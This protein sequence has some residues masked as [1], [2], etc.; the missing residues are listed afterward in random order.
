[1]VVPNNHGFLVKMII[2]GCLGVLPFKETPAYGKKI[3]KIHCCDFDFDTSQTATSVQS[4]QLPATRQLVDV[5]FAQVPNEKL[6]T[7]GAASGNGSTWIPWMWMDVDGLIG[8][9]DSGAM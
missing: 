5:A 4:C 2:L 8:S 7:S 9:N 3:H 6:E 1:M